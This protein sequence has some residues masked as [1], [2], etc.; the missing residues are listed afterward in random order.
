MA[1][2]PALPP[3]DVYVLGERHDNPDHHRAQAAL[4]ARI[5]PTALAFEML[6]PAQAA[7]IGPDT[8][9]DAALGA[10]LGWEASGWPDF[11]MY[12]PVFQ[13]SD[14][15]VVGAG[16]D[17]PRDLSAFALDAPLPGAEQAEREAEQMAAHCDALPEDLLP[18]FVASQ[19]ERDARLAAATLEALAEHGAPVVLV[20]GNGH[21]R[22]DRGVPYMIRQAAPDVRVIAVIQGEGEELP[23][24]DV[25][26]TSEAPERGDPCDAFR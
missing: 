8:A 9:R 13:A 26:L 16:G 19:R 1:D 2:V 10:R 21:A 15:P 7:R 14:A 17:D 11:A 22:T 25:Q 24:G 6:T 20:A 23:P 5:A 12:L 3:A 18:R 4:I